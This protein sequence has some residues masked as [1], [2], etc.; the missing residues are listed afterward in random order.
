MVKGA[1]QVPFRRWSLMRFYPAAL[2]LPAVLAIG[3]S[4]AKNN[5]VPAASAPAAPV[6]AVSTGAPSAPDAV[7]SVTVTGSGAVPRATRP[8]PTP[9]ATAAPKDETDLAR[10][11]L[12][13]LNDFPAGYTEKPSTAQSSPLDKLCTAPKAAGETGKAETGD[14]TENNGNT[15]VSE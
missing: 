11:M 5:T 4:S 13:T 14:F 2:L 8:A 10:Q 12:I 15:S 6:A 3:C 1:S 7:P 9:A